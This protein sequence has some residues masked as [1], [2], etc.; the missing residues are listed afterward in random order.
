MNIDK[1]VIILILIVVFIL[2]YFYYE[3]KESFESISP[4]T[5]VVPI[6]NNNNG[7]LIYTY[8]QNNNYKDIPIH[9]RGCPSEPYGNKEGEN[10]DYTDVSV[11]AML[12]KQ[13]GI[14]KIMITTGHL[15]PNRMIG[16]DFDS[17]KKV[18][19]PVWKSMFDPIFENF[20][21]NEW[22]SSCYTKD[23]INIMAIAQHDWHAGKALKNDY[24]KCKDAICNLCK[25]D[26]FNCWWLGLTIMKSTDGG[27]SYQQVTHY[28]LATPDISHITQLP[29]NERLLKYYTV[30]ENQAQ[31]VG[32]YQ[33]TNIMKGVAGDNNY[34]FIL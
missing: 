33:T 12:V 16:D 8:R 10:D 2:M 7:E 27:E 28:K 5:F 30:D 11:R 14:E 13:N 18:C 31:A 1:N 17:L 4:Q 26:P 32:Y 6:S 21:Y 15:F 23:G 20:K 25:S 24:N 3:S 9:M 34:Y 19:K 22:Y 29:P